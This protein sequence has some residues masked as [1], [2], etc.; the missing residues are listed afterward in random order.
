MG[1]KARAKSL[2][3]EQRKDAARK[4]VNARWAKRK[5]AKA[6]TNGKKAQ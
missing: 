3:K 2:T 1:G 5:K 6:A 4:A